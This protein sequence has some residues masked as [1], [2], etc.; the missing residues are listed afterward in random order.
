MHK[1]LSIIIAMLLVAFLAV[2]SAPVQAE[3]AENASGL[4]RYQPFILDMQVVHG[5]TYLK[6]F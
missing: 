2:L 6:T 4:W 5:A 3:P 1:R